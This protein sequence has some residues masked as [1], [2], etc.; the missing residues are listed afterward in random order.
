MDKIPEYIVVSKL[1]CHNLGIS[2]NVVP[3]FTP[4]LSYDSLNQRKTEYEDILN[5][6]VD[7]TNRLIELLRGIPLLILI[8]DQTGCILELGG[9]ESMT[10]M[11][12]QAG[13]IEGIA[14]LE[15]TIGTNSIHLALKYGESIQLIGRDHYHEV[16]EALASYSI[17]FRQKGSNTLLGTVTIMTSVVH[18]NPF[19]LPML[20]TVAD[21][22]ER[23]LLLR[24]RNKR[25]HLLE[26]TVIN[27]NRN[28]IVVTNQDGIITEINQ[29]AE[30]MMNVQK[31]FMIGTHVRNLEPIGQYM[32]NLL[33]TREPYRDIELIM[34]PTDSTTKV[35]LMDALPIYDQHQHFIGTFAQFRDITER[36]NEQENLNYLAYHD[37]LTGLPNRRYFLNDLKTALERAEEEKGLFALFFL[38]LDRF[39]VINDTLGHNNGD[40]LLQLVAQRLKNCVDQNAVYRMGG[41]E[42]TI[43]LHQITN[44]KNAVEIAESI[45]SQFKDPFVINDFE[46]FISTSIGIAVY[47]HDGLNAETLIKNVDYAMYRAKERGKNN[48]FVYKTTADEKDID[49]LILES[50]LRKAV[51]NNELILN[52]QPKISIDTGVMVGVEALIRWQHPTLGV[53]SPAKFIPLAEETGLISPIGEWV[54]KQACEQHKKWIKD[55]LPPIKIAINLSIRQFLT[56]N[57]VQT[58]QN[59]LE[60]TGVEPKFLM[61]EITESMTMDVDYAIE[62]LQKL[63]KIGLDISIDDFGTGY[64]SLNYLKKFAVDYLKIDQSFVRDMMTDSNDAD[65]VSTIIAMAHNLGLRVIAEGVETKEQLEFL[66]I[67]S[68]DEVQGYYFKAPV[69]ADAIADFYKSCQV[70]TELPL[71]S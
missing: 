58:I 28:G 39:K 56:Q 59:V 24:E 3:S 45:I 4:A 41:D 29:F 30:Q 38:D 21:S 66:Q 42:F 54:L 61:L 23:E 33:D 13:I 25:L 27:S 62:T 69:S 35:L 14:F 36:H 64:S 40:I 31:E 70:K 67:H 9:D 15:E 46:F 68:C 5:T 6:A 16:M 2:P 48:F 43:L 37:D 1:N 44:V 47:P 12:H 11:A 34:K 19:L 49:H 26:E 53:I 10:K 22:I 7:S 71:H 50:S 65:I 32:M 63:K 57:L 18:H 60:N 20:S 8:T 17:P 51:Q 55:G 52:Y